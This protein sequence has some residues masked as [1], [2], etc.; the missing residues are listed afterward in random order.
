MEEGS[1]DQMFEEEYYENSDPGSDGDYDAE[2]DGDADF[3]SFENPQANP[4]GFPVLRISDH[5]RPPKIRPVN[6]VLPD[7]VTM[8]EH[9]PSGGRVYIVG[10]A[11][12]GEKSQED[13]A[14]TIR[15]LT[16]DFVI[17]ELCPERKAILT[18]DED[19]AR[20]EPTMED[21]NLMAKQIGFSQAVMQFFLLKLSA[22]CTKKLGMIPGGEMRSAYREAVKNPDCMVLLGDR[23]IS[24][25]LKRAFGALSLWQKIQFLWVIM[26]EMRTDIS[27]EDVEK[28]KSSDVLEELIDKL[29]AEFPTL[30]RV[31]VHERDL[32]LAQ[33]LKNSVSKMVMTTEG[34]QGSVTVGVVGIGHVP[35]IKRAWSNELLSHDELRNLLAIPQPSRLQVYTSRIVMV[36]SLLLCGYGAYRGGRFL[37][38]RLRPLKFKMIILPVLI[39]VISAV[40]SA[41]VPNHV[42]NKNIKHHNLHSD[43]GT[44][45]TQVHLSWD[46]DATHMVATWSTPE[47]CATIVQ[48]GQDK[49]SLN[50]QVHGHET[51][52]RTG[53]YYQCEQFIHRAILVDMIPGTVYYYRV[54]DG[55]QWS[56]IFNFRALQSGENWSPRFA[57]YGDFGYDN[58]QSLDRLT[59]IV[60]NGEIDMII[61]VGDFAYD[62]QNDDGRVGD[63]FL[64]LIEPVAAYV[65]YMTVVGNHEEYRNFTNYK[66]RFTMPGS[67]NGFYYRI[68]VGPANFV[69]FSTEF[70]FYVYYG[71]WQI[72]KQYSWLEHELRWLNDPEVRE[73]AP[74]IITLGHRPMY[75]SNDDKD[76]CTMHESII[77]TGM[78]ILHTWPLEKLFYRYGVDMCIWAHE[79]SYERL[80]PVYDR[81]VYNGSSNP[82]NAYENPNA[83]VHLT[84]GSAG[85]KEKHDNFI[86]PEA[87][88]AFRNN[89]YGFMVMQVIN[90]THIVTE[91]VSDDQSGTIID[92]IT[93]VKNTHGPYTQN[94]P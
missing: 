18:V 16:P 36:S 61:H 88:S 39:L 90:K 19:A 57:I 72:E 82:D 91:Q 21:L 73:S 22:H 20:S 69:V 42:H 89:D 7:T 15:T 4:E 14:L 17:L 50:L 44:I 28:C 41:V 33:V 74:W 65:P 77:R 9:A 48:Y 85:C 52:F 27:Q 70:Y 8:L 76:D 94:K 24:I 37:F 86:N 43:N 83:P 38:S 34:P 40:H 53:D 66:N 6:P 68:T 31:L 75:C 23:P 58:A 93:I 84:S 45:P 59:K 10:T 64:Q 78:P 71:M 25:T 12:F 26:R 1:G 5:M 30:H 11:H 32:F 35:G 87:W 13:V 80:W 62:M 56:K 63:A 47:N 92:K 81:K 49:S 67:E 3:N 60:N 54:G 2:G 51:S 55:K 46:G 79:H 29:S